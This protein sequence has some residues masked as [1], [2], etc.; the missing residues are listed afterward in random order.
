MPA[1][2]KP[3]VSGSMSIG[4]QI[5]TTGQTIISSMS[6]E[7][8]SHIISASRDHISLNKKVPIPFT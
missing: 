3:V 8:V 5:E 1:M 6:P 4:G 7:M 2:A